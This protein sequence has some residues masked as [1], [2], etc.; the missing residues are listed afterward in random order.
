MMD[1]IVRQIQGLA[2]RADE[3]S[4]REILKTLR[5]LQNSLEEPTDIF[6]NIYNSV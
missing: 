4:R 5:N 2:E 1:G 3:A 6:L